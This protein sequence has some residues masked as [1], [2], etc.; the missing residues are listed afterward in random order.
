ML[1]VKIE[2]ETVRI[3][4]SGDTLEIAAQVSAVIAGV[5]TQLKHADPMLAI[6]FR[7]IITQAVTDPASLIWKDSDNCSG[8]AIVQDKR[9][10]EDRNEK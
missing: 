3:T 9:R 8:V 7:R 5:H 1:E 4:A 2:N 6:A 10:Q